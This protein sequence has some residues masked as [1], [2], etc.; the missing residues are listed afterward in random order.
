M[1]L[2]KS[3]I[4]MSRFM[5][6]DF[7][8]WINNS[9]EYTIKGI[10]NSELLFFAAAASLMEVSHI[11]ESG[12]A[13]GHSTEIISRFAED[14]NVLFDSIESNKTNADADIAEKR[15]LGC[16][17]NLIYGDSFEV[18]PGLLTNKKTA[19]LIDGPKGANMWR[20]FEKLYTY[21]SVQGIFLHDS[22]RGS[23]I[24][25][26]LDKYFRNKYLSSDAIDFV[27]EFRYLDDPCWKVHP[28]HAYET[29]SYIQG[30]VRHVEKM[31][32]YSETL[33]FIGK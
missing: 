2:L 25:H 19:V 7:E 21:D 15:L 3:L 11:I 32:S 1:I 24:R 6:K 9:H 8:K 28:W 16:H 18:V 12:R 22:H 5:I 31:Q 23:Y 33:S 29:G 17:V 10:F 30:E 4:T 13:A 26:Q 27:S 20:L 14:K